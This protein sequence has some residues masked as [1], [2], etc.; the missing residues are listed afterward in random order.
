M[1]DGR[2]SVTSTSIQI[3]NSRAPQSR[4]VWN[5]DFVKTLHSRNVKAEQ[6]ASRRGSVNPHENHA[7]RNSASV[8][9]FTHYGSVSHIAVFDEL[10]RIGP[11]KS[12]GNG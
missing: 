8:H 11:G 1:K 6:Q 9:T 5:H 10:T 7:G 4:N 3:Q 2:L 12:P